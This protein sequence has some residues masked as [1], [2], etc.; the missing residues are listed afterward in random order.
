MCRTW[1][2]MEAKGRGAS[3]NISLNLHRPFRPQ[4]KIPQIW[5]ASIYHYFTTM[6][7]QVKCRNCKKTTWDGKHLCYAQCSWGRRRQSHHVTH[8]RIYIDFVRNRLW[9]ACFLRHGRSSQRRSMPKLE[10]RGTKTLHSWPNIDDDNDTEYHHY[11]ILNLDAVLL[12]EL[13]I[14]TRLSASAMTIK[15]F[16][17]VLYRPFN[18]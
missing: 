11:H 2:R 16:V 17:L 7:Y 10:R 18:F 5:K 3:H 8:F 14:P 9:N 6:C 4:F 12:F 15:C 13:D 1:N